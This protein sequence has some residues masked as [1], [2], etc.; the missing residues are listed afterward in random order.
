LIRTCPVRD[1]A[2]KTPDALALVFE[3][4]LWT[5]AQLD[6]DVS[7]ATTWLRRRGLGEGTSLVVQSWNTPSLV[8]LFHAALRQGAIFAPLNARLLASETSAHLRTLQGH[9]V[10]HQ[11]D[12]DEMREAPASAD[13]AVVQLARNC[14]SLFTSGTTGSP[15]RVDLTLAN[16]YASATASA[17]NLGEAPNQTWLGTLP[18]FHVGGIVMAHRCAVYGWTLVLEPRFQA[19]RAATLLREAGITH[20]S[21]VPTALKAVLAE[22]GDSR[23]TSLAAVLIGGGPMTPELLESARQRGLPVLQTYGLTEA[24]SQVTTERIE[25]A[26]GLSAGRALSGVTVRIVD[27]AGR[28]VAAGE[29]GEIEVAGPTV[30]SAEGPRL[31][32]GD[33]GRLDD[34]GRLFVEARRVDLIVSGGEN[35]APAEVEAVMSRHPNVEAVAVLPREDERWGQIPVGVVVL[36]EAATDSERSA[37]AVSGPECFAVE[38]PAA[39]TRA[40]ESPSAESPSAETRAAESPSA[41]SP[42]AETSDAQLTDWGRQDLARYKVPKIWLRVAALPQTASGKIDRLRLKALVGLEASQPM[43][44]ESGNADSRVP[45]KR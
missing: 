36:K 11:G 3:G 24:T 23:L 21:L 43:G 35:I 28:S 8:V 42:S 7:R 40:A 10:L 25:E 38:K 18:L 12:F 13:A 45:S 17:E 14:V 2:R 27:E 22:L 19:A 30:A 32:T 6:D 34:R 1:L 4:R 37:A 20:A 29:L 15:K 5:Y 26:D 44:G 31:K 9:R 33:L 41:A 16:L 39:E